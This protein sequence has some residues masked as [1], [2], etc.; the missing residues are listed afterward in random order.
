MSRQIFVSNYKLFNCVP[1]TL[2]MIIQHLKQFTIFMIGGVLE[3]IVQ[4]I[5]KTNINISI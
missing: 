1:L 5:R 2:Q 3:N 4:H